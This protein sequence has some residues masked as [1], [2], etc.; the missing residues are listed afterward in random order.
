MVRQLVQT[1]HTVP[2]VSL[3]HTSEQNSTNTDDGRPSRGS[4]KISQSPRSSGWIVC[5]FTLA[6]PR[7]GPSQCLPGR[8]RRVGLACA[9]I[10][11]QA[12][13]E[14]SP[15]WH[16]DLSPTASWALLGKLSAANILK[17]PLG[18]KEPA[19]RA[20][21]VK[22]ARLCSNNYS[23]CYSL[24]QLDCDA[25]YLQID[26]G[27]ESLVTHIST[28]SRHPQ[29]ER[30]DRDSRNVQTLMLSAGSGRITQR[31]CSGSM[32][33]ECAVC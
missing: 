21:N 13:R 27:T 30:G 8:D 28:K 3:S 26:L 14:A 29:T 23:D 15:V 1:R 25:D 33:L 31:G 18:L 7:R 22:D 20:L 24:E 2:R 19:H 16:R 10:L 17:E 32:G 12:W 11:S 6:Y 9:H 4:W 5:T